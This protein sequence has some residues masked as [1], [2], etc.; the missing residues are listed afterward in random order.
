MLANEPT[1]IEHSMLI[2]VI[3]AVDLGLDIDLV[4]RVVRDI[5]Y[6]RHVY[7]G[8]SVGGERQA[9]LELRIGQHAL[10]VVYGG[11]ELLELLQHVPHTFRVACSRVHC[12]HLV[13]HSFEL[14]VHVASQILEVLVH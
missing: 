11:I 5:T 2:V 3:E 14:R 10:M 6:E 4:D 1:K 7:E 8:M 9:H 13:L 12:A